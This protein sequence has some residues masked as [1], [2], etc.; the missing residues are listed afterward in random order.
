[1]PETR[2]GTPEDLLHSLNIPGRYTASKVQLPQYRIPTLSRTSKRAKGNTNDDDRTPR[3]DSPDVAGPS[4]TTPATNPDG[5][6]NGGD[7]EDEDLSNVSIS[8]VGELE[9]RSFY[10]ILYRDMK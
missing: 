4:T 5:N 3:D 6:G 1:M 7:G 2:E 10:R 8:D 9:H